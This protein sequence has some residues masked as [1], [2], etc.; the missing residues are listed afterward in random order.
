MELREAIKRRKS[1]RNFED[2]EPP[3]LTE[4]MEL[5][6]KGPSAGAIRGYEAILSRERIGPY[7]APVYIVICANPDAYVK[8]YGDRGRNLY[9]I[10]DATIYGAYLQLLLEEVGLSSCWV[11][12]FNEWQVQNMLDTKL[13]PIAMIAVGFKRDRR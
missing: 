12:A 2:T 9:A 6:A 5:A 3:D 11:G 13:R 4:I 10:Q 1:V 7:G 8:R